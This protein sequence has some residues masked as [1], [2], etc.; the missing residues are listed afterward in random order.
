MPHHIF[1]VEDHEWARDMLARLLDLEPDLLVC[2]A[3]G[4]AE[5]ALKLLPA[6]ADLVIV[7]LGLPGTSGLQLI[8]MIR[9]RW[10]ALPCIVLS[11]QP[12]VESAVAARDAGAAG[13]V[14]KGDTAALFALLYET[15]GG[16]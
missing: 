1:I 8:E 13:Y 10:P 4:S 5:A 2:G 12:A 9:A 3:V 16:A 15:L 7:D 14:E 11:A 6:G